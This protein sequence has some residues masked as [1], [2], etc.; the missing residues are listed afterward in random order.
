MINEKVRIDFIH[1]ISQKEIKKLRKSYKENKNVDN[2][3]FKFSEKIFKKLVSPYF[4]F[5]ILLRCM[6]DIKNNYEKHYSKVKIKK[7][8]IIF[9][10]LEK[11]CLHL[12]IALDEYNA[13]LS[14]VE[15]NH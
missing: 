11:I 15:H 1:K 4:R 12:N 8:N 7:I 6:T 9:S 13:M 3:I 5:E 10:K 2:Y 14:Y